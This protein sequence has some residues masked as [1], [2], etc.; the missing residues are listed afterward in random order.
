MFGLLAAATTVLA[1]PPPDFGFP[2]APNDTA[3]TV[4]FP[5]NIVAQEGALYGVDITATIPTLGLH[6]S[7]YR[8]L[9]DYNGN[10][11]A[12]F[13]DPDAMTPQNP[14]IRFVVQWL[15]TGMAQMNNTIGNRTLINNTAIIPNEM[16]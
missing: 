5:N 8:S 16:H 3:L 11:L 10:Y 15:Q 14:T 2:E 12:I 1:I 6:T 7:E 9:A 13:V 4:N